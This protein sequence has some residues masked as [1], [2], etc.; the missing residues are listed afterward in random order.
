MKKND[1]VN[2]IKYHMD[3]NEAG[4]L[5]QARQIANDFQANGDAALGQYVNALLSN[6][7]AISPQ[8]RG[9]VNTVPD[10]IRV[11]T[12]DDEPLPLPNAIQE[13]LRGI[14]NAVGNALGV[15]RF[16][17]QGAPGTGKT[18]SAKQMARILS[19]DLY[20]VETSILIDSRLGHTSKNIDNLFQQINELAH[21]DKVIILFDEIDTLAMD[22][23]NS[24]DVR[25]MGR[26]TSAMLKG[27]DS[28][29]RD[30]TLIATT[31]LYESFDPALLR[32]FDAIV[33]FNRYTQDDL[34]T[35]AEILMQ[36]YVG[37][38][39]HAIPNK[40]LF[41]K[42]L[43]LMPQLPYPGDMK[44]LIRTSLAFSSPDSGTDYLRRFY[45]STLGKEPDD[46]ETLRKEGFTLKEIEVLSGV[47]KSTAARKISARG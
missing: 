41:T 43:A 30:V 3:R 46:P 4:F 11:L 12:L 10:A 35:I 26:A 2:L 31:N 42:I 13:D 33:D 23:V 36:H 18:E 5:Q 45:I 9:F 8:S 16:L 22:R 15:N 38:L 37:K 20:M 47:A 24:H 19:R 39:E 34:K 32:R 21:P 6:A 14:I 7:N 1:V 28:L 27:L 17:F 44:N 40:R 25:E 29:N